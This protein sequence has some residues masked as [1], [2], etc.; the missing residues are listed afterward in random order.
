MTKQTMTQAER[1]AVVL[2]LL[3][4]VEAANAAATNYV[5]GDELGGY[6]DDDDYE[7]E[8]EDDGQPDEYTEWQDFMGGD[9]WDQGQYDN[10]CD[11]MY[12]C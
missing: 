1:D 11:C 9:D 12:D 3:V 4:E 5:T 10:D 2:A 6:D 7:F 8:I